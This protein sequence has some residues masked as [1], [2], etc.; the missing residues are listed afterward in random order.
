MSR[1]VRIHYEGALYHVIARGNNREYIF[2]NEIDK[3]EYLKKVTKYIKKY[4]GKL[5]AYVIMDNH[6]HLLIEVS[7]TPLSKIMQL[8]QQTYTSWY[9]RNY[10]RSGHV[11]EQRY[12]SIICDKDAY[13]LSLIRYIHQNPVRAGISDINYKYSSHK[14]YKRGKNNVCLVE[15][16]LPMFSSNK[17]KAIESYIEFMDIKNSE[18]KERDIG[19]LSPSIEKIE[20]EINKM[21][22]DK[23]ELKEIVE[24]FEDRYGIS[25]EEIKGKY[26][27][28][29]KLRLRN[30]FINEVLKYKAV[31][32]IDLSKVLGV[33]YHLISKVWN[34]K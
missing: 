32:Q 29:E 1:K 23:K 22:F 8:I 26:L 27:R 9:N 3:D 18:V 25:I 6:C 13:L 20:I 2:K 12:K 10:K 15:E 5:Y 14:E 17:E 11:F 30:E 16:V 7:K 4:N 33:S 19:D 28:G 21:I 34:D 24:L 31:K